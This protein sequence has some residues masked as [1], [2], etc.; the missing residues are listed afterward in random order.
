MDEKKPAIEVIDAHQNN[1]KNI[2][3][4]LPVGEIT[5]FTGVSG[6]GKSSL[7]FGILAA[8]SQRQLN[9]TFPSYLRNRL[10]Q[11]GT[12]QVRHISGLSTAIIVDQKPIGTNSRSTV[13]TA[14][15]ASPLLRLIFSRIGQPSAGYSPAFSF[16]D[17]SGMCPH[18]QGSG[19][20]FDIDES[21]LIDMHKSINEGAFNFKAYHPGSWYWKWYKRTQLFDADKKLIDYTPQE[22]DLLLYAEP[23]PLKNPPPGWYATAKYEGIVHRFR[24]M[25][26]DNISEGMQRR[27]RDD[28]ERIIHK[29]KCPLCQGA[30]LNQA[31]L[32]CKID[33]QNIAQLS[34]LPVRH[35]VDIVS[36]WQ[37]PDILP[38]VENLQLLLRTMIDLGLGYMQLSR[39]TPTLSGGEAQRIKMVRHLGSSLTRFT[40]IFDEPST[41]LH[42]FEVK[43]F[44]E[45]LKKLRDKGNTL[46]VVE[47]DPDLITIADNIVDMG[48]GSGDEGGNVLFSGPYAEFLLSDTATAKYMMSPR[49][50][51]TPRQPEHS[52]LILE[53]I[54]ENNL[55]NISVEIYR[56]IVTVV[57]G[58]AGSGKSTLIRAL[59]Q[60]YPEVYFLDQSPLHGSIRSSIATYLNIMDT[61]RTYFAKANGVERSWFSTASKGACEA[62][63]GKGIR[64][65]E[66]AF[67]GN[68]EAECEACK[69]S[70]YNPTALSYRYQNKSIAEVM[71][72]TVSQALAFFN[73]DTKVTEP[74]AR[75]QQVGA[76]Y[77]TIGR[78]TSTLSGGERQRVKLS[79]VI[80]Q[81]EMILVLDE[82]T[83]GLHGQDVQHFLSL[84]Q[85][86]VDNGTTL[87]VV[88]HNLDVMLNAD[89][90]ID[91]G[92]K[93]GDEGGEIV[94]SGP[95]EAIV[96][97]ERS[98]TGQVLDRYLS[99]S[100]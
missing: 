7:V 19:E 97:C 1:L 89:W 28:L 50:F 40:Y 15:D 49:M 2:S 74:L 84:L 39:P 5:V 29:M 13:G 44:G 75:M 86:L 6:S 98:L 9:F 55:K 70:G 64:T 3:V 85:Q 66:L 23:M 12:P 32:A 81:K 68:A 60:R 96:D 91:L 61:L 67:L 59:L 27:F 72:L 56:R 100:N 82:P 57:T 36:D 20:V 93:A 95:A 69:G 53:N 47:H 30:R 94:Y 58:L 25:F 42:P 34:D 80:A 21:E 79:T 14:T 26:I 99:E 17:P 76:G 43:H 33:G 18:C 54:N 35:L 63:Q 10:P 22:L 38:A 73:G 78:S 51:K 16:N 11:S 37:S 4:T 62:C 71:Q 45:I 52:G 24:K 8:E 46:F 90:I 88:E 31:A 83:T 48:P 92:P 65:T 41:G 77:L 87:I